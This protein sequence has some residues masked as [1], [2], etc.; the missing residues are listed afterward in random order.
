MG[1]IRYMANRNDDHPFFDHDF[2]HNTSLADPCWLTLKI[3]F[4]LGQSTMQ[5]ILESVLE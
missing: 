5:P 4:H 1:A 2:K 3:G